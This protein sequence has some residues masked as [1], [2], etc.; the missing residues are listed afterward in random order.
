MDFG[1]I[2]SDITEINTAEAIARVRADARTTAY[3]VTGIC[4][5]ERCG[6]DSPGRPFCSAQC[7]NEFDRTNILKERLGNGK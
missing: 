3:K 7:R 6:D 5:N 2:G 4:L 1:D